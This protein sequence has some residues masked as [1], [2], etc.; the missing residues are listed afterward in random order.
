[1]P[2]PHRVPTAVRVAV[3]ALLTATVV[4]LIQAVN[5]AWER[6]T[7]VAAMHDAVRY[8]DP[9]T[10]RRSTSSLRDSL[11][12]AL[13]A[14]VGLTVAGTILTPLVW[15][16]RQS[17][18]VLTWVAAGVFVMIH[19]IMMASDSGVGIGDYLTA[20]DVIAGAADLRDA[21]GG[22]DAAMGDATTMAA[23]INS[24]IAPRQF[25][26]IYYLTEILAPAYLVIAAVN[27]AREPAHAHFRMGR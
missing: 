7:L 11:E 18:R 15:W 19:A 16:S 12:L 25:F 10:L 2:A 4:G 24:Q 26:A 5:A 21:A 6:Q 27:L 8:V 22:G 20:N 9:E 13:P 17:G 14:G 1:M 3:I 23:W